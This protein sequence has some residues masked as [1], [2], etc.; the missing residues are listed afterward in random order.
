MRPGDDGDVRL[1]RRLALFALLTAVGGGVLFCLL[2]P[3]EPSYQGKSL[4]AWIRGLEIP[5]QPTDEQR[6]ALR[7]MGEPAVARLV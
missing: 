1:R 5:N 7:A 2:P 6:A 4:S 3:A